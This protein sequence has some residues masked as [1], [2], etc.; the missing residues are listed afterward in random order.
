ML[1][2]P[3][4]PQV[5]MTEEDPLEAQFR[6]GVERLERELRDG[7]TL[8]EEIE[9][10]V[11]ALE[12]RK[13]RPK[14][15]GGAVDLEEALSSLLWQPYELQRRHSCAPKGGGRCCGG[16]GG[17]GGG[18][19]S[20]GGGPPMGPQAS[21]P[22]SPAGSA[23]S[24][25]AAVPRDSASAPADHSNVSVVHLPERTFASTEAQTEREDDEVGGRVPPPRGCWAPPRRRPPHRPLPDLLV[26]SHHLPPPPPY[27][28]PPPPPP[29]LH[30]PFHLL[31]ARRR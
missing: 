29:P 25:S 11:E 6:E 18:V 20:C 10:E 27:T 3:F 21:R 8:Q 24:V 15:W 1:D 30:L 23:M 26:D 7:R 2:D 16:G 13:R 14:S 28:Q 9:E 4:T 31:P 19:G 5:G 17:C 12:R 22:L